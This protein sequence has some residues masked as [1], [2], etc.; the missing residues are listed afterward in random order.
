M[1]PFSNI[2][3]LMNCWFHFPNI[4]FVSGSCWVHLL[5]TCFAFLDLLVPVSEYVGFLFF[6]VYVLGPVPEHFYLS[7]FLAPMPSLPAK[8]T[9]KALPS[10]ISRDSLEG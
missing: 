7:E 3:C 6:V 8:K 9:K 10:E 5:N 1:G 4:L 2:F